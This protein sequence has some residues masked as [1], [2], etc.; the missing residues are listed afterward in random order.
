MHITKKN[1]QMEL[2]YQKAMAEYNLAYKD[3]PEDAQVGIDNIR[4]VQKGITMLEKK[5]KQVQPKTLKKISAMDKW[6]YYEILDH[7][8]GTD[9]ND[10]DMGVDAKEVVK[11]IKQ[12][13]GELKS[14]SA[15]P[16]LTADQK[17]ALAIEAEL[18]AMF[19]SGTKEWDID[20]INTAAPK[21]YAE[22]FE[23]YDDEDKEN[24][25]ATSRY[26]LLETSER[27]FTI[28]KK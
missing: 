26:S 12:Q 27:I 4:D 10:D 13:A 14:E 15:A 18:E 23:A 5:G 22:L 6:V 20:S 2:Q 17:K 24:G 3:L 1:I 7:V 25:V 19:K 16:E 8:Q 21:T 11:E 28:T 9:E